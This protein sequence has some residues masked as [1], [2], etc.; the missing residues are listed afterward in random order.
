ML[1]IGVLVSGGGTNLQ[2]VINQIEAGAIDAEIA[3]VLSSNPNAYALERAKKYGIQ[4]ICVRKKDC[5]D[6]ETELIKIFKENGV[7]LVILAGFMVVLGE[8]FI[9]AFRN[10]IMNIHP[11]LIPSFCGPGCYGL[12]VHEQALAKGVKV[13]GATVHFVNEETDGGP[14]ILQKPVFI[15]DDDTPES[16]QQRVMQEAE[17]TIYPRAIQLYAAGKLTIE[18]NIV[19]GAAL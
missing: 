18:N 10:K 2:A 14:I 17:W 15:Q 5:A 13:T 6:Y 19:K 7:E 12:K 9:E 4:A 1:K 3:V 16:L 11:S 8:K